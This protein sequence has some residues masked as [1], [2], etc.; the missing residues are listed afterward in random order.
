MGTRYS[1][2]CAM[3]RVL[4]HAS[5]TQVA[6]RSLSTEEAAAAP[7]LRTTIFYDYN[8][9]KNADW[10]DRVVDSLSDTV[11]LTIDVDGFDPAIMP[12][13][14][15]PEP[16]GLSWYEALALLRRVIE[17]RTVV[18]PRHNIFPQGH[19][20]KALDL[21]RAPPRQSLA[22]GIGLRLHVLEVAG[23]IIGK[24]EFVIEPRGGESADQHEQWC[25]VTDGWRKAHGILY[26]QKKSSP[27]QVDLFW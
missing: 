8:M 17:R 11:Y 12:A 9:R 25:I 20:F 2:A 10:I 14:G 23:K 1:H 13:T 26:G 5:T 6:I 27:P 16:G 7:S 19:R 22:G 24:I 3:R 18:E 4:E 21:L 15:T